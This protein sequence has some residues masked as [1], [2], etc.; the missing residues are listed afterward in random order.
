MGDLASYMGRVGLLD[1]STQ[2]LGDYPWGDAERSECL[3][4][5]A[6]AARLMLDIFKGKENALS[7]ENTV[8]ICTGPLT[9]TGVPSSDSF[10][11]AAISPLTGLPEISVCCGELGY[12]LKLA[13]FDA[14]LIRGKCPLPMWVELKNDKVFFRTAG[15][16]WGK[17]TVETLSELHARID[18]IRGCRVK[19][20]I[21]AI[22][23]AGENL[24]KFSDLAVGDR[25][26][27]GWGL[28]AVFGSKNLKGIV[29]TGNHDIEL[30]DREATVALNRKWVAELKAHPVTGELLPKN[31]TLGFA[32]AL[33]ENGLLPTANYTK[34]SFNGYDKVSAKVFADKYTVCAKGCASCPMKCGRIASLDGAM[35]S[36][37]EL[38]AAVL[39]GSGILNTDPETVL[40]LN[41]YML[42]LGLDRAV[43]AEALA[44]AMEA[45][46]SGAIRTGLSFGSAE[47]VAQMISDIAHLNG[48][49]AKL[50][51]GA[52][53][54]DKKYGTDFAVRSNAL[55]PASF[56]GDSISAACLGISSDGTNVLRCL[57]EA[58]SSAGQCRYT[59]YQLIP[60]WLI[61]NPNSF[62]TRLFIKLLPLMLKRLSAMLDKSPRLIGYAKQLIP[63]VMALE[64]AAGIK[65]SFADCLLCGKRSLETQA[66]LKETFG[67][68]KPQSARLGNL[69]DKWSP[70]PLI[71]AAEIKES[72]K[73]AISRLSPKTEQQSD[74]E[75]IVERLKALVRR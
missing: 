41:D 26:T 57:T 38:D 12:Y 9:G 23:P 18:A 44:W 17:D 62:V 33:Q 21:A 35:L 59:A 72:A 6:M 75:S 42:R 36:G 67:G 60:Q 69:L 34:G 65:M 49:G 28:G 45:N 22:G 48:F 7:E 43:C 31:G 37:P 58:I 25:H 10:A 4:G 16:M 39:L 68:E 46:E 30:S 1:L 13:G 32:D 19:C 14:L 27:G 15:S 40:A 3:G 52:A 73:L 70:P 64:V 63:Q 29:V 56:D 71:T 47:N 55:V 54:L 61:A 8:L 51:E 66:K 50:A 74:G 20:G 11:V 5:T 24:V 53:F 2:Q